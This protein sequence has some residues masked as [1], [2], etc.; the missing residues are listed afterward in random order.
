MSLFPAFTGCRVARSLVLCV[1]FCRSLRGDLYCAVGV[2]PMFFVL[3][4]YIRPQVTLES[5]E[6]CVGKNRNSIRK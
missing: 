4:Q 2:K 3:L 6:L 5:I 1:M